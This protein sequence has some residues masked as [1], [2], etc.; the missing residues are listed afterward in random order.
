MKVSFMTPIYFKDEYR[1]LFWV[2]S[3]KRYC[4]FDIPQ[5][6]NTLAVVFSL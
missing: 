5:T 1:A 2:P 4:Y 6:S 3:E